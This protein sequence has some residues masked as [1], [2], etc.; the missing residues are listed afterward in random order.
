VKHLGMECLELAKF[1]ELIAEFE[2]A[3]SAVL[4]DWGEAARH[5]PGVKNSPS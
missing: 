4:R 2:D 3:H 5:L 1:S